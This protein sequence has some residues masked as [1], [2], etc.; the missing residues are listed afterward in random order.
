MGALK[1]PGGLS[2]ENCRPED[3]ASEERTGHL[4]WAPKA[5]HD[6]ENTKMWVNTIEDTDRQRWGRSGH[7]ARLVPGKEQDGTQRF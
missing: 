5:D 1:L 3:A 6:A 4:S 2:C 7:T